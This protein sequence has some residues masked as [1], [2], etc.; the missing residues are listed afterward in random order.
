MVDKYKDKRI[1]IANTE[2]KTITMSEDGII[3]YRTKKGFDEFDNYVKIG[4]LREVRECEA[5]LIL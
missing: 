4:I 2:T 3:V 5:A 1:W